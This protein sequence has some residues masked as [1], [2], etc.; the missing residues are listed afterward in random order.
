MAGLRQGLIVGAVLILVAAPVAIAYRAPV[1]SAPAETAAAALPSTPSRVARIADFGNDV[2]TR[3]ARQLADWI[4]DSRDNADAGFFM[5]D[6][7]AARLYVFGNDA[8]LIAST[9]VLL[10]AAHG[11][12][13]VP[14]IGNRP[15]ALI[16]AAERTTPAGRFVAQRGHNTNGEDVVW[17]DYDAAVSMHRVRSAN[18]LERRL[19]RLATPEA[20]DNRISYG[21]VNVPVAFYDAHVRPRFAAATALVYVLPEIKPLHQVF[22]SYDVPPRAVTSHNSVEDSR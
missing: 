16:G 1:V 15:M 20:A 5:V 11:D 6:K 18:P 3:E 19:E 21:C 22:G 14:G 17:I 2:P 12:D 4:A 10:G 8:R 9:A 7:R 13:S